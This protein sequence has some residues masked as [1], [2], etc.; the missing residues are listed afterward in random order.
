MNWPVKHAHL[1]HQLKMEI[2][3]D[4]LSAHPKLHF[5]DLSRTKRESLRYL[6]ESG[7]IRY[8]YNAR[9][10]LYQL[11]RALHAAGV[12][13]VLVP[14]FHCT[15]VVE[16]VV[17]AGYRPV[18]YRIKR[19]L[20]IDFE[21]LERKMTKEVV[22]VLVVHF[23]GFPANIG[24]VIRLANTVGAL[25][26]E[27]WAHSFLTGEGESLPGEHG[28]ASIYSFYKLIPSQIGGAFRVNRR[29]IC[30]PSTKEQVRV[31]ESVVLLKRMLEQCLENSEDGFISSL[32]LS[33]EQMRVRYKKRIAPLS[34]AENIYGM[35]TA[36]FREDLAL[37]GMPWYAKAILK[38]SDF[39]AI[40][41]KRRQ[42][43]SLLSSRLNGNTFV[44]KPFA[45]LPDGVCPW[46][47]PVFL[48][49]RNKYDYL[50]RTMGVPLYTYGETLHP[51]LILADKETREDAHYLSCNLLML[52]IHQDLCSKHV[53][54]I[55]DR[56]NAFFERFPE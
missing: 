45:L 50:L 34:L 26:I 29:R 15:S 16:P 21:D 42:N 7:D 11:L 33:L 38:G 1:T 36:A 52:A 53:I 37:A 4:M 19:D 24:P 41:A 49:D 55:A 18:F 46:A 13:S 51:L 8:T 9:G 12:G 27:D 2:R 30:V 22:A 44:Q 3:T 35:T 28:D 40:A 25:V 17:H 54:G 47:Y 48:R 39:K 56:I 32:L 23:C 20:S 43:Y 10:G 6:A 14:A 31:R 5:R